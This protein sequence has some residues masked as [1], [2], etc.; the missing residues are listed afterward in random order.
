MGGGYLVAI[1]YKANEIDF[2][3]LGLGVLNE[4]ISNL[5]TEERNG[6]FEL[7]MKYPTK[8]AIF[9]ELKLDRLIKADANHKLKDQRFKIIRISKPMDGIVTVFAEHISYLSQDLALKPSVSYGGNANAA[10]T[11]WKNSIVDSHPFT[12]YSDIA[13]TSSGKWSIKDLENARQAL[14]GI[15]GSIL[16]SYGGE[17][18]FDNYD[19]RLYANRGSQSDMLIAYGRNLTELTQEETIDNTFT[20]IYPYTITTE[21]EVDTILTLPEYFV[22]SQY[23]GNFARRKIMKVDF[24][25]DG[26]TTVAQLRAKANSYIV[27]NG[28]GIPKVNLKVKFIDLAKSLDYKDTQSIEEVNLCDWVTVYFEN[29]DI[30]TN[31]KIIKVVW[32]EILDQYDSIEIGEARASLSTSIDATI[33]GKLETIVRNVNTVQRAANGKNKIYRGVDEPLSG[34]VKNDL[35]YKPVGAG[36]IELYNYDGAYWKIE[37]VSAGLLGGTL[38]AKNGDVNLIN[39]NASSIVAESLSAITTNTGAL[40]VSDWLTFSTDNKGIRATYDFGDPLNNSFDP[41]WFLGS[42]TLGYRYMKFQSDVYAVN[43]SGGRGNFGYYAESY[44]GADYFK[45]RQ[46]R[47]ASNPELLART[48]MRAEYFSM[49]TSYGESNIYL[50][51]NGDSFFRG[52]MQV[53]GDLSVMNLKAL[54]A[55]NIQAPEGTYN[56][57]INGGRNDLG[58]MRFG[59]DDSVLNGGRLVSSDSIYNRTYSAASNVVVFDTGT[60]GRSVSAKKYKLNIEENNLLE[61]ALKTLEI[62]PSSWFDKGEVES[63]ANGITNETISELDP[64]FKLKRHHGFIADKFHEKGATEVVIYDSNGEVEGL[65]YDRI[66]MYHHELIKDLYKK[67]NNLNIK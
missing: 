48:D 20:S 42:Y 66:S 29:F 13:T 35:W 17:Y 50:N 5:I 15:S 6:V 32:D 1:L 2:S 14:G 49:A 64:N 24:S 38:D 36:E 44:Y 58:S 51:A 37:K 63:I 65:A 9:K 30:Q 52:N 11:A 60:I 33:D 27:A 8:G 41:R 46:F 25:Q 28:I 57:Y 53:G 26:V 4:S 34:M 19:V 61:T 22:D 18:E 21:N 56:T 67:I 31:A 10:L 7:E 40:N 39:V 62:N 3:H 16:D 54:K 55:Y 47:S 59:L 43:S 12:V 23:V 45:L